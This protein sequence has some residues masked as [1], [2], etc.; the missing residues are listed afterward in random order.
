VRDGLKA[1]V[2]TWMHK[3]ERQRTRKLK[4]SVGFIAKKVF[5]WTKKENMIGFQS[6]EAL[7]VVALDAAMKYKELAKRRLDAARTS[8]EAAVVELRAAEHGMQDAE[9]YFKSLKSC[10]GA[11]VFVEQATAKKDSRVRT[12][13]EDLLKQRLNEGSNNTCNC[14]SEFVLVEHARQNERQ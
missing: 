13:Q 6:D 3:H 12:E 9:R 11:S 2:N 4:R 1:K 10:T 5:R 14:T 7:D 8:F